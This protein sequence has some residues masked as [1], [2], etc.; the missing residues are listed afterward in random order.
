MNFQWLSVCSQL[1]P[2]ISQLFERT[3]T[4]LEKVLMDG[5]I[6]I[7]R[8]SQW[9]QS[10]LIISSYLAETLKYRAMQHRLCLQTL[11]IVKCGLHMTF[12][13]YADNCS[14][15]E[16]LTFILS[17]ILNYLTG[18]TPLLKQYIGDFNFSLLSS[19]GERR[20]TERLNTSSLAFLIAWCRELWVEHNHLSLHPACHP[21]VK[22]QLHVQHKGSHNH[23]E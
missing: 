13:E 18:L 12:L 22:G 15:N 3:L 7:S 19:N 16:L 21:S 10:K 6:L 4:P 5:N 20:N 11:N 9:E 23:P 2:L 14:Y 17:S 8:W 1:Y